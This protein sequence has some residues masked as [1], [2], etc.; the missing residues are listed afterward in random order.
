MGS[1]TTDKSTPVSLEAALKELMQHIRAISNLEQKIDERWGVTMKTAFIYPPGSYHTAEV[2]V[3]R[4]LEAIEE[5][6]DKK[7]KMSDYSRNTRELR[8]Y[9]VVFS[10]SAD[11]KTKVF[12]K[13]GKEP[14]KVMI[15]EEDE[16]HEE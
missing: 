10:Q 9:G 14:P 1:R 6:L 16:A 5:A 12:V 3:R 15:V 11:D 13:A 4:G 8:H 2:W 7:A